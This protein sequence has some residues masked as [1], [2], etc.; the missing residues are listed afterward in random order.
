[1]D[2]EQTVREWLDAGQTT[3]QIAQRLGISREEVRGLSRQMNAWAPSPEEIRAGCEA[4][5]AGWTDS[6]WAAAA[7]LRR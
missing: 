2:I 4:I 7:A 1:M 3:A 6:D 5:R